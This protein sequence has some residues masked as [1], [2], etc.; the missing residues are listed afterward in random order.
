MIHQVEEGLMLMSVV[1][2][3]VTN[4]ALA[5]LKPDLGG[6]GLGLVGLIRLFNCNLFT[7]Y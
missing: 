6:R 7:L 4:E 2:P 1:E 3:A 5:K